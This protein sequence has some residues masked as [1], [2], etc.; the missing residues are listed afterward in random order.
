M[1]I[2]LHQLLK[3]T[4]IPLV[5]D[6]ATG[7]EIDR[8]GI[9]TTLPLWSAGALETHPEVV[10]QIHAD[11]IQA[12]ADIITTN[13]FRTHARSVRNSQR[14]RQLTQ[15][16]VRVAQEA[17]ADAPRKVWVAG[18]I[19]PLEDC[20]SPQLTP[21]MGYCL[22]E[23]MEMAQ[24][25]QGVDFFLIETMN[26]LHEAAAAAQ[27]AQH[28]DT[29]FVVSYVLNDAFD[30][31]SGEPLAAAIDAVLPFA[32]A[33]ILI[34]CIPT[35]HLSA[36][37]AKLRDLTD[38]PIGAYG[39]MGTPDDVVGWA[40]EHDL[41]PEIYCQHATDWLAHDVKIIGSCCGSTPAHTAAIRQLVNQTYQKA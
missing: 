15:T 41:S 22:R 18:S 27:V 25:L 31:F 9:P 14:A 7:T 20:Y 10:R 30:L 12:G 24:N 35:R 32:P 28:T 5:L 19:A 11:Y 4:P 39:N 36:A 2:N 3:E 6:G 34:N 33:A 26:T 37:L 40:A 17:A 1:S 8:R 29:P 23:H 16:A 21:A 38:L 13:T